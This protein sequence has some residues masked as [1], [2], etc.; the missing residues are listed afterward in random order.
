MTIKYLPHTAD[1]RMSIEAD[2]LATLF[3]LSL[4]GMAEILKEGGCDTDSLADFRETLY[5]EAPDTT[6]L[7]IDF[8]SEALSLSYVHKSIF[9]HLQI[10]SLTDRSVRAEIIGHS[11]DSYD[12]EI[13]AVTY[14]EAAVNE[15]EP[16]KWQTVIVFDI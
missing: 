10:I 9:C 6:C 3:D 11:I 2:S 14:H 1:I 5:M 15:N 16:G 12:E 7:L 13:K 8:L 4:K